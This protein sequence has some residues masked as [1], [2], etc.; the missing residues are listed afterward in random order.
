[1][2][3]TIIIG[4]GNPVLSDDSVGIKI[5]R[6]LEARLHGRP[7]VEVRELSAGGIRLMEAMQGYERA[8]LVDAI[9]T[10][11][12][13]AGA[14]YR[15]SPSDLRQT[16][17]ACCSHDGS[18][19][20]AFEL[21]Q[22]IGLV[23]PREIT[24]WGIEAGDVTT[25]SDGLTA[26]VE[27]AVAKVVDA[28]VQ[29]IDHG[30]TT[31]R[32]EP[33]MRTGVY[34]CTCGTN[35]SDKISPDKIKDDVLGIPEVAYFK[36]CEYL[37]SEEGK[38]FLEQ[39]LK[40]EKP[41]RVVV[42]AC[43]P[44]DYEKTFRECLAKAEINPYL[45]Q[46][47]NLREQVAWVTADPQAAER[48]AIAYLRAAT[49]R[50]H[51][52]APL[53][54]K[55]IDVCPDVL[56][57][58]AGP[59]GLKAAM[60]LA[61]AGRK[62][63]LVEKTPILGGMPVRYEDL[64]PNL[65]CAP[66]MLEPLLAE[67]VEEKEIER[68]TLSEVVNVTGYCGNFT[69]KIRQQPRYVDAAKCI[70]CG[71]CLNPC[72]AST[73]N[74]FNF[75]LNQRKAIAFAVTGG[76]P[77]VPFIDFQACRRS[78]GEDCQ[79]CKTACPV[80]GAVSFS[81]REK[82][83]ERNVGGI[84][85]AV[86]STL[87][88]CSQFPGLAYGKNSDVYT[89]LEFERLLSASGP[90]QGKVLK[91]NGEPPKSVAIVHCVG[92]LDPKQKPYCS[93]ICC[94][95]AFK[96]NQMIE[97]RVEDAT[98]HHFYREMVTP[99]KEACALYERALANPKAQF[100]RYSDLADVEV[101]MDNGAQKLHCRDVAGTAHNIPA[102]M[103][104]LCPAIVPTASS[105]KLGDLLETAQ[106]K[107]GFFEELHGRA[108]AEQSKIK[109]IYLAGTCQS[110]KD[111]QASMSQG[112]SAAGHVLSQLPAGRKLKIEPITAEVNAD[113]CSGCK[114]C[115]SICPYKAIDFNSER[116]VSVVNALLCHGC[117]TCVAACPSGAMDGNHFTRDQI[118]AELDGVLQ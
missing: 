74:E 97:H 2:L 92:S 109:G 6:L 50:V 41:D 104:I 65:E 29:Q 116:K 77:N 40:Q 36:T 69:V 7:D 17:N 111:V 100:V 58:G 88:D 56:V 73:T 89:S 86:G 48:K 46:M 101:H 49:A 62:T 45:M 108:D 55:E 118:F 27:R 102:D 43:S 79:L 67:V 18:L 4:L 60:A 115:A 33:T 76:L 68:L 80:E 26:D 71:E 3:K 8:I 94:Q 44:R 75:G 61:R 93:G 21:G 19:Q 113:F 30:G 99:G 11:G 85:L 47:V 39:D 84:I 5:A 15:L 20:E 35:I 64:F 23:L 112:M 42:S 72:P 54:E 98:V 52:Q 66:C 16:R 106:D 90:T 51:W 22:Q 9:V 110:P 31:S 117:G 1:M 57:V 34:F 37:C 12:G 25:F 28:I 95:Y 83:L 13:E 114:V 105:K 14:V 78:H 96:F 53:E 32:E 38:A 82:I 24:I 63:V 70:G 91:L 59:A 10:A 87:Y 107:F 103:V 81:A